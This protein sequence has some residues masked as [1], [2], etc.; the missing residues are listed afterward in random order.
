MVP[1]TTRRGTT[2]PGQPVSPSP[3]G[4]P[5]RP[6][7]TR[8]SAGDS[9]SPAS[10]RRPS[11]PVGSWSTPGRPPSRRPGCRCS[12]RPAERGRG[13]RSG[14][15]CRHGWSLECELADIVLTEIGPGLV[16][17]ARRCPGQ[18]LAGWRLV[19]LY[20]VLARLR[21]R[22]RRRSSAP[23]TGSRSMALTLRTA[24]IAAGSMLAA[25]PLPRE[26]AKGGTTVAYDLRPLAVGRDGDRCRAA[27]RR[28]GADALP[29]GARHRPA[30]RG[31]RRPGRRGRRAAD[32]RAR[33]PR[34][35]GPRVRGLS[36]SVVLGRCLT[37]RPCSGNESHGCSASRYRL[38]LAS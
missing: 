33:R 20:D 26:R 15:P 32:H 4:S 9:S 30:G 5:R 1:Q 11:S 35:S 29:S 36:R 37:A 31:R 8:G 21:R 10:R 25:R 22:S 23:T 27:A 14:P 3:S 6:A 28:P 2:F 16:E 19:D 38:L 7:R 34:A 17:C 13:S 24:R 18:L 12:A